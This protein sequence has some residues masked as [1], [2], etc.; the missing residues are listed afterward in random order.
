MTK[1]LKSLPYVVTE[2]VNNKPYYQPVIGYD[3][4]TNKVLYVNSRGQILKANANEVISLIM[5]ELL[6]NFSE[7]S[8]FDAHISDDDDDDWLNND[9]NRI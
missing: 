6:H 7:Q 1:I 4:E 3:D 9:S 2:I 5:L 8:P